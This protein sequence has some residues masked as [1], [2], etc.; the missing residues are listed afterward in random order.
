MFVISMFKKSLMCRLHSGLIGIT[1][2]LLAGCSNSLSFVHPPPA[3]YHVP[4]PAEINGLW[5][6]EGKD[7]GERIRVTGQ[8]DGTARLNFIQTQPSSDPVPAEPLLA[9][10]L[11]FDN[12]DWL[13]IDWRKVSVLF[14]DKDNGKDSY[15][16]LRFVPESPDRLCGIDLSVNI[17]LFAEAI[18]TGR[19]AGK[20]ETNPGPLKSRAVTVTSTGA[21]WVNWWN[22]LPESSKAIAPPEFCVRRIS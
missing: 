10:T 11:R 15:R 7:R 20:V 22:T 2:L 3:S 5:A 1:L 16:L 18:E 4:L 14:G 9:Q 17:S 19:L 8:K 13:L 21:D 12:T 6:F